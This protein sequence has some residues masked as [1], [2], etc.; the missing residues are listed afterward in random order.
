VRGAG[1]AMQQ[2]ELTPAEIDTLKHVA[3]GKTVSWIADYFKIT[4]R[5]VEKRLQCTRQKLGASNTANAVYR[6]TILGMV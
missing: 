1:F 6:A 5:A 3:D 2:I 4:E